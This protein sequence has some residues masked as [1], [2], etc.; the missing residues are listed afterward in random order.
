M[1][2]LR[3]RIGNVEIPIYPV[4]KGAV[5]HWEVR[6]HVGGRGKIQRKYFSDRRVRGKKQKGSG[7]RMAKLYASEMAGKAFKTCRAKD[8]LTDAQAYEAV[9]ANELI[10]PIGKTIL[11]LAYEAVAQWKI[12]TKLRLADSPR[13]TE[14]LGEFL[15]EKKRQQLSEYHLRDLKIRLGKFAAAFQEP[16]N[17]IGR[18]ELRTWLDGLKVG[19]R[20]WNNYREALASLFSFAK[21]RKYLPGDWSELETMKSVD[22]VAAEPVV[23]TPK[24]LI[25]IIE[26]ATPEK[27]QIL[28]A[29]SAFAGIRSEELSK[30]KWE[31]FDWDANLIVLRKGIVKG[32]AK[33]KHQRQVPI[34]DNLAEWLAPYR[35]NKGLVSPYKNPKVVAGMKTK[36]AA[37][38][39]IPWAKNGLRKSWISYQL[40]LVQIPGKV[41]YWAGNSEQVI[42]QNY[43]RL[44]TPE[45]AREWFEIRQQT[46]SQGILKLDFSPK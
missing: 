46:V 43:E 21:E 24:Q 41:A 19:P 45:A 34:S 33:H 40:A 22:L 8:E 18:G 5:E 31:D 11:Q 32:Q 35:Y 4:P 7:L 44:V 30:L 1:P 38:L 25:R 37:R 13:V 12:E 15:Q 17:R 36:L 26:A 3:L 27:F 16:V 39:G 28:L 2:V 10:R 42:K 9:Q 6:T 29:I 20:T 23:F 14:L